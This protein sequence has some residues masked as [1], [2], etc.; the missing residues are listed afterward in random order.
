MTDTAPRDRDDDERVHPAELTGVFKAPGWLRD[1]GLTAW[2][3]V[4]LALLVVGA[5]AVL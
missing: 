4:G 1:I 3:L 2:L 5:M